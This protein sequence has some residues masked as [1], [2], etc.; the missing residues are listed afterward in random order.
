MQLKKT[1]T[2]FWKQFHLL[3]IVSLIATLFSWHAGKVSYSY[4]YISI[5]GRFEYH[6][7]FYPLLISTCASFAAL[8]I[9]R[10]QKANIAYTILAWISVI[11]STL[12]LAMP[13]YAGMYYEI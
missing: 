11:L 9:C 4:G 13:L 3:P 2:R 6:Q 7:A 8:L 5:F 12:L 1:F 10:K